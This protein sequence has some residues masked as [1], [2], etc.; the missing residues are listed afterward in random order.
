[1]KTQKHELKTVS[2]T[3]K[4]KL[5]LTLDQVHTELG[6]QRAKQ[7]EMSKKLESEKQTLKDSKEQELDDLGVGKLLSFRTLIEA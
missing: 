2:E 6:I 5:L 1:M 7:E 3:E 4:K